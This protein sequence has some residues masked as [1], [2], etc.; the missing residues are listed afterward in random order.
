MDTNVILDE[1]ISK[2]AVELR[3]PEGVNPAVLLHALADVESDH[4]ARS[5]ATLHESA[6]CYKGFYY[7]SPNGDDL[8][9]LSRV[10][11][12]LAHS[13]YSAWQ[14]LY[15]VAYEE[16][17]RGDPCALRDNAVAIRPVIR[18]LNRRVFDRYPRISLEGVA[19]SWNSG[20]PRDENVPHVYVKRFLEAYERWKQLAS[21]S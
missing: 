13:S 10:Y 12:C 16:G 21:A 1:I 15:L 19:D 2:H 14:I 5:L 6:Y 11:G 20:N 18:V 9:R 17:F 4:G 3:P 8:R 7:K